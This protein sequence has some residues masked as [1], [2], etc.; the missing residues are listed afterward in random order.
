MHILTCHK[1]ILDLY[2]SLTMY[3]IKSNTGIYVFIVFIDLFAQLT[4]FEFVNTSVYL[5]YI[6]HNKN[7]NK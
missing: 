4:L 7:N 5:I 2:T 3:K 1:I 6:S